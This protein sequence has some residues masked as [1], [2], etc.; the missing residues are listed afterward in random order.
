MLYT[1]HRSHTFDASLDRKHLS[2]AFSRTRHRPPPLLRRHDDFSRRHLFAAR[3]SYSIFAGRH[4]ML[5][6]KFE[7]RQPLFHAITYAICLLPRAGHIISRPWPP[8]KSVLGCGQYY[9]VAIII[10]RRLYIRPASFYA[11]IFSQ[12]RLCRPTLVYIFILL[13][14]ALARC[15]QYR[16]VAASRR[17]PGFQHYDFR[18]VSAT[19]NYTGAGRAMPHS[20]LYRVT[21]HHASRQYKEDG[22]RL[23]GALPLRLGIRSWAHRPGSPHFSMARLSISSREQWP[24]SREIMKAA[25][26]SSPR[27]RRH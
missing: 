10:S 7:S 19:T 16:T 24:P 8:A 21:D 14:Q 3:A 22:R 17:R 12:P 11:S 25:A 20:A 26:N 1:Q 18:R 6:F 5:S 23:F 2:S 4:R 13:R 27:C 15:C 9:Y